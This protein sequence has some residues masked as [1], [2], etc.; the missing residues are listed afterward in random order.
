MKLHKEYPTMICGKMPL[1]IYFEKRSLGADET[2]EWYFGYP[3]KLIDPIKDF[4]G[5]SLYWNEYFDKEDEDF[6]LISAGC[7]GEFDAK[8]LTAQLDFRMKLYNR[9]FN[10][11]TRMAE[12]AAKIT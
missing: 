4:L 12:K 1:R 6:Y 8:K 5:T 2:K 7:G 10:T 9:C 3:K 11:C